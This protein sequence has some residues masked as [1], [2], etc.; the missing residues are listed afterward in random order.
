[1]SIVSSLYRFLNKYATKRIV[2][3]WHIVNSELHLEQD[4]AS[5]DVN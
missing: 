2:S 5:V 4:V 3:R 1:M